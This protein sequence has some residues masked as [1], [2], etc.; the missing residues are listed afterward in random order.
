MAAVARPP[1]P[2]S[3]EVDPV[4]QEVRHVEHAMRLDRS[5]RHQ[6]LAQA[7]EAAKE[8]MSD[9]RAL[10]AWTMAAYEAGRM[11]E[12]RHAA[13]AWALH[14]DT[15]EPRVVLARVLD[16]TGHRADA[17]AVLEEVLQ[18]HPDSNEAR[19]LHAKLGAPLPAADTEAH[20]AQVARR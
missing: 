16:A 13:E 9:V 15:P 4:D 6:L 1:A 11:R 7:R 20:R 3:P 18:S 2:T 19:R 14:D 12:A 5:D 17:Q 10:K 8:H